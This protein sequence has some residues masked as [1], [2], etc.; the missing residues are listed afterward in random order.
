MSDGPQPREEGG[1]GR[2]SHA[3]DGRSAPS[4]GGRPVHAAQPR[5]SG[6]SRLVWRRT[7]SSLS[8]RNYLYLWLGIVFWAG[9]MQIQMLAR[10]YLVYDL[11]DSAGLLGLVNAAS[12]LPMLALPLLGGAIADRFER[13]RIIQLGQL[14][15]ML[16]A[17]IV[18]V[19]ITT[20]VIAWYHLMIAATAQG[21]FFSF[22][23]PAR[24]AF[25]AQLVPRHEFTN[26]LALNAGAMSAMTLIAPA[27]GGALYAWTGPDTVYYL[28]GGLS[29]VAVVLTGFVSGAS[30]EAATA[31]RGMARATMLSD[32]GAGLGY[33][34]GHSLIRVL[35]IVTLCTTLLTMPFQFLMP[36]FVVDVYHLGPDAMGLLI[37]ITGGASLAGSLAIAAMG[38]WKRGMLLIG[39]SALSGIALMLVAV[40]PIYYAAAGFMLLLGLGNASRRTL[41]QTLVMEASDESYRGRVISLYMMNFGLIQLGILPIGVLMDVLGGQLTLGGMAVLLLVVTAVTLVTQKELREAD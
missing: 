18:G 26:A 15:S 23:M 28:I 5:R 17:V 20:D 13:K 19:A 36:V 11:T 14:A 7:F 30:G 22:S 4:A 6:A 8:Y 9:G 25:I 32:I 34:F 3:A 1:S 10:A 29:A 21:V 31:R 33:A 16:L 41:V 40:I 37:A 35:L 27:I 39:G 12:A 24:Q 2:T 38:S